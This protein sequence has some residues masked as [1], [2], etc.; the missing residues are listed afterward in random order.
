M[1]Q[2]CGLKKNMIVGIGAALYK[3]AYDS[4]DIFYVTNI[5]VENLIAE[6]LS[7][8]YKNHMESY[9]EKFD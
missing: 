6:Y 4:L 7:K 9:F 3:P 2:P 1:S 5:F 8:F